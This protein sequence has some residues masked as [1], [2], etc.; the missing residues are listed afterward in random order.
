MSR[1][2]FCRGESAQG[3]QVVGGQEIADSKIAGERSAGSCRAR[4]L[5]QSWSGRVWAGRHAERGGPMAAAQGGEF[6]G[7]V[8]ERASS[9]P[10]V[11]EL[12]CPSL[13]P[14]K[15]PDPQFTAL[16][17]VQPL[18]RT[19]SCFSA[20]CLN[21]PAAPPLASPAARRPP[22]GTPFRAPPAAGRG[23]RQPAPPGSCTR[24]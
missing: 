10:Q 16:Q 23:P 12:A 4:A 2:S 7:R 24:W 19:A 14:L 21:W 18:P 1:V 20:Q 5:P 6:L 13:F 9:H 17:A 22:G 11:P 8:K 3:S 15:Q